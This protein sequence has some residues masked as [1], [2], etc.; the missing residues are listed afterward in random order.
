MES[1]REKLLSDFTFERQQAGDDGEQVAIFEQV[2]ALEGGLRLD[3]QLPGGSHEWADILDAGEIR[4][5]FLDFLH[6]ARLK[7]VGHFAKKGAIFQQ[8]VKIFAVAT[9]VDIFLGDFFNPLQH[10]VSFGVVVFTSLLLQNG[11]AEST[12]RRS[13]TRHIRE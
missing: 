5:W 7:S 8:V 11:K 6:H 3:A 4:N 12:S 9:G 10:V 2:H 13:S 1:K